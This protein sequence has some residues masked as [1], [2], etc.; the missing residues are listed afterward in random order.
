MRRGTVPPGVP[1]LPPSRPAPDGA[2]GFRPG[3]PLPLPAPARGRIA[4]G[5]ESTRIGP[6]LGDGMWRGESAGVRWRR[7]AVTIPALFLLTAIHTALLPLLLAS[8][9]LLDVAR[10][11]PL[12]LCRFH[13]TIW[14]CFALHCVGL[15]ALGPWWLI[16]VVTR[17]DTARW[18]AWHRVLEH[19]WSRKLIGVAR[20][21]YGL[22]VEI[23][24]A[25][26]AAPGPSAILMRHASILDTLLPNVALAD[27]RHRMQM[28]IIK[29]R[30]L[31]WDP[32]VDLVSSRVPRTFVARGGGAREDDLEAVRELTAG[33]GEREAVVIFP[34]GTRW[35]PEKQAEV[36]GKLRVR[37]PEAAERAARLRHV[38]PVR[39]AGTQALLDERPD[40]DVVFCA[41]TGL[42]GASKLEDFVRGTLLG[43]T[44]KIKFWRVPR[45]EVPAEPE[46]QRVWLDAWWRRVD[47]WIDANRA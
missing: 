45:H 33:M 43:R 20:V 8:G 41:H 13:L 18:R 24:D 26:V 9:L 2:A 21:F 36:L 19:W 6:R 5:T 46:A 40:L 14:S 32:C 39:P 17:M 25:D 11:R 38:L 44:W 23:E 27:R 16:G 37:H 47:E 4:R 3:A 42:E 28:R 12:L 22:K 31:L 15:L 7:R 29:K 35:T 10:R 34:E 1:L 30:E